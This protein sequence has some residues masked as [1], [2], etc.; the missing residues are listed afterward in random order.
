MPPIHA[1]GA[2]PGAEGGLALVRLDVGRPVLIGLWALRC[3]TVTDAWTSCSQAVQAARKLLSAA[4]VESCV[5][6][7]EQPGHEGGGKANPRNRVVTWDGL[8]W[9]RGMIMAA[10]LDWDF[11]EPTSVQPGRWPGAYGKAGKGKRN[12][13]G[14]GKKPAPGLPDGSHRIGEAGMMVEGAAGQ[15]AALHGSAKIRIDCAEAI[16]IAGAAALTRR[17]AMMGSGMRGAA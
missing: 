17:S 9:R 1:I 3:S 11:P 5:V 8:G 14:V 13:V 2:D 7:V 15:L 12:L 4:E 10:L 6:W 16:L